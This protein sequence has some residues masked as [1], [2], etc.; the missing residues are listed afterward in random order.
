MNAETLN[1]DQTE[2]LTLVPWRETYRR[3]LTTA[4][5]HARGL[6]ASL[7]GL[8]VAAALQGLALACILPLFIALLRPQPEWSAVFV[9]LA[10]M[11]L[12]ALLA[13]VAR[14]R[15]MG[16]DF[17]GRMCRATHALRVQLGEQLRRMPLE[18]LQ[19]KRTGELSAMLLGNVDENLNYALTV[20]NMIAAA[21]VAP[22]VA[23]LVTLWLDWRVGLIL[24]LVFPA[25]VPLYR[26]R[27]PLQDRD[28]RR[29]AAAHSRTYA[30]I[31]EYTQGLP[32]LRAA[33]CE[34][35]K[36]ERLQQ[37]F[38]QLREVQEQAERA[39][40]R[41]AILIASV[42]ELGLLLVVAAGTTWVVLGS[43]DL[44][45]LAAVMVMVVRFAEP[46]AN[47]INFTTVLG[48]IEAAL[49][50][51]EALLAIA[52]LAQQEPQRTPDR[53][54]IRFEGVSF[55]YAQSDTPVIDGIDA[56]LA[57]C[58]L[59][60][61]VGPS[62]SGKTTLTRLLMRHAD[63]QAGRITI[64]GVDVR[65]IPPK[66]LNGLISA[67]FQDVYLFDDTVRA[68]IRMA[69]PTASDAEV[70]AAARAAQCLS[71]IE[72]LPQGW[73]TRLGEIGGRLSGGERQRISIAR[74]LLKD[75]PIVI[76]DEPTAALDTESEV[77]VQRAI[78][79]LVRDKTVI[80]IAHRLSTIA[81]A[82]RILVIDE[83]RLVEQ[84]RHQQLL[85]ADGRYRAMW[86]A[87]QATKDWHLKEALSV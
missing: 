71:F 7:L 8:V 81:G 83:G 40:A 55:R 43:L 49:A 4:G 86:D 79:A 26:W 22:L 80:V 24:L 30:D 62:G 77:A 17:D 48:I 84:G 61:L 11:T 41:P 59:T 36:A 35:E 75:A 18:R 87:Q 63:V 69:R 46:L 58:S 14:W 66:T 27:R 50:R 42:V 20:F 45:V 37:G 9:W 15:A 82:D 19:D 39:A 31:L 28:K 12:L 65:A 47:F 73:D 3:L 56:E 10:T 32:V 23:A 51:I 25:I 2:R 76:L 70:E 68:N 52:P 34:G 33:C 53:Y 44:A 64:G 13:T 38:A 6:R 78:D 74:A 5:E 54:D 57:P 67:V 21:V 16:F 72:R 60:A 1:P 85:A 29:V